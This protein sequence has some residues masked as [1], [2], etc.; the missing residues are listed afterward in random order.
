MLTDFPRSLEKR[1]GPWTMGFDLSRD[2]VTRFCQEVINCRNLTRA[3]SIVFPKRVERYRDRRCVSQ[4]AWVYSRK[5]IVQTALREAW[6]IALETAQL[7]KE[8]LALGLVEYI[9][10]PERLTNHRVAG[11][12]I[13]ATDVASKLLGLYE[14]GA[15]P[16][17]TAVYISVDSG[18]HDDP[19]AL[20]VAGMTSAAVGATPPTTIEADPAD[21]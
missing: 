5:P 1:A 17:I 18:A 4:A 21:T 20:E 9:D 2:A 15:T 10:H 13:R 6:L 11:N 16:E 14:H 19:P 3:F 12:A 7:N 8:R